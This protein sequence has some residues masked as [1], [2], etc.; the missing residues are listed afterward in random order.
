MNQINK[1][2]N[3]VLENKAK[4]DHPDGCSD[5]HSSSSSS[6]V[7]SW[8]DPTHMMADSD[9]RK[10]GLYNASSRASKVI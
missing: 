9:K 1:K 8:H 3:D 7:R 4:H 10:S 6:S 5:K 2:I